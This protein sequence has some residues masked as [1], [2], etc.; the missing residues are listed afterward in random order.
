MCRCYASCKKQNDDL[1]PALREFEFESDRQALN[2]FSGLCISLITRWDNALHLLFVSPG[3]PSSFLQCSLCPGGWP[4]RTAL[5]SSSILCLQVGQNQ[6]GGWLQ[7]RRRALA[8]TQMDWHPYLR[9]P[10]SST[11]RNN[12]LSFK[13]PS[14]WHFVMAGWATTV[15][16]KFRT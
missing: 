15:A 16:E 12:Y 8:R 6:C 7:T 2:N 4:L 9:L 5:N 1:V 14:L 10:A 13:L 3:P 11:V